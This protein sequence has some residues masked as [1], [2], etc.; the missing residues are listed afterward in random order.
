[1][2]VRV[3]ETTRP[4]PDGTPQTYKVVQA[5]D[6]LTEFPIAQVPIPIDQAEAVGLAIAGRDLPD[7]SPKLIIPD[8]PPLPDDLTP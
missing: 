1:M 7:E 4:G 8:A 2:L 3:G 6:P 5:L